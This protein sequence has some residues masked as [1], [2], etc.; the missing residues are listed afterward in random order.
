VKTVSELSAYMNGAFPLP[1]GKW[2]SRVSSVPGG[3]NVDLGINITGLAGTTYVSG[4]QVANQTEEKA[5]SQIADYIIHG[6]G[7]DLQTWAVTF[8][9]PQSVFN[10]SGQGFTV[11]PLTGTMVDNQS[12][13]SATASAFDV[14]DGTGKT[15]GVNQTLTT[16][17]GAVSAIRASLGAMFPLPSGWLY[18]VKDY[19]NTDAVGNAYEVGVDAFAVN[20]NYAGDTVTFK[21]GHY[22]VDPRS[23]LDPWATIAENFIP[24]SM[25]TMNNLIRQ[26]LDENARQS[27]SVQLGGGSA[28]AIP[29]VAIHTDIVP[30]VQ[31]NNANQGFA[32]DGQ[33]PW[34]SQPDVVNPKDI[35]PPVTGTIIGAPYVGTVDQ[36]PD[37][38]LDWLNLKVPDAAQVQYLTTVLKNSDTLKS[39][40]GQFKNQTASETTFGNSGTTN[41]LL[42]PLPNAYSFK[43]LDPVV[44]AGDPIDDGVGFGAAQGQPPPYEQAA[45]KNYFDTTQTTTPVQDN[46]WK[47]QQ[48]VSTDFF[49]M[50]GVQYNGT[51][52]TVA[53]IPAARASLNELIDTEGTSDSGLVEAFLRNFNAS[54]YATK[55]ADQTP[56]VV[57][58]QSGVDMKTVLIGLGVLVGIYLVSQKRKAA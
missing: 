5:V 12:G 49:N 2:F 51:L 20:P 11:D 18:S 36:F 22:G 56:A 19:Q 9:K 41:Q 1:G 4:Y 40:I 10:A 45:P 28:A 47:I 15:V 25:P 44:V 48:Q 27:P 21:A 13:Q 31:P 37:G 17:Q 33:A 46:V 42:S 26:C 32:S 3:V 23:F 34:D 43:G 24:F 53:S 58:K 16:A 39:Y 38:F 35:V 14:K 50:L 54:T 7:K 52:A 57:V 6:G 30:A 8:G 29:L 55:T